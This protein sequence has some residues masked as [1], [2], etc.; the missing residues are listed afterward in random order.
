MA[1]QE[2]RTSKAK[3][4]V[5]TI[6]GQP[7]WVWGVAGA[8]MLVAAIYFYRRN[9]A[10]AQAGTGTGTGTGT[11]NK[12]GGPAQYPG[13]L[14]L[15]VADLQ[16][17]PQI[18]KTCPAGYTLATSGPHAGMCVRTGTSQGGPHPIDK[19]VPGEKTPKTP[20]AAA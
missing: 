13:A 15:T 2:S 10:N 20:K 18:S 12:A 6:G 11:G 8:A 19:P 1:E 7:L 14:D 3:T 5:K 4:P 16:S 9:A 17:S